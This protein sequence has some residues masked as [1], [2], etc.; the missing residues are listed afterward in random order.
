[1]NS[2]Y[3]NTED[4][5]AS[6]NHL[7]RGYYTLVWPLDNST[8]ETI[9]YP[10]EHENL[11]QL[12]GAGSI[13]SN[14]LDYQ[15][16]IK[17][18][19][20]NSGPLSNNSQHANLIFPRTITRD[21]PYE[22]HPKD[23]FTGP[24]QYALGWE[25]GVYHGHQFIQHGGGVEAFGTN[26]IIFP[27]L[28]YG[29]IAFGNIASRSNFAEETLQ[30]WLID[31]KLGVPENERFDWNGPREQDVL[32]SRR[33]YDDA[34][35]VHFPDA[36]IPGLSM[37]LPSLKD[38]AATYNHGG[39]GNFTVFL[40]STTG[41]LQANRVHALFATINEF[42]HVSGEYFLVRSRSLRAPGS[43][44]GANTAEFEIGGNGKTKKLGI[45]LESSLKGEKIWFD[46][47]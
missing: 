2:T 32:D 5:I 10:A 17:S 31:E 9:Y 34:R 22:S 12:T 6:P 7:A 47:I 20:T 15:K 27:S 14:V 16:W 41:T 38:Y 11:G 30:W 23:P 21:K 35:K 18:W 25:T 40:N 33:N 28:N 36:P 3:F 26:L 19:L 46:R 39:Y 45:D 42:E 1:M 37:S 13:A 29:T 24:L 4:A 43:F 8:T 44:K